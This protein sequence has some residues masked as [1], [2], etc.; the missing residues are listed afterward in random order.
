ME[1]I[2]YLLF[3]I[4]FSILFIGC[5]INKTVPACLY[6]FDIRLTLLCYKKS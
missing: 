1:N 4:I 3:V 5:A 2:I 6:D